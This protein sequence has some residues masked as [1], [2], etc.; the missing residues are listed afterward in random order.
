MAACGRAI[1]AGRLAGPELAYL[2]ETRGGLYYAKSDYSHALADYSEAIRLD[3]NRKNAFGG[4]GETY[5]QLGRRD[6]AIA[7]Y[8]KVLSFSLYSFGGDL[9]LKNTAEAGLKALGVDPQAADNDAAS[10]RKVAGDTTLPACDRAIAAGKFTGTISHSSTTIAP[11]R[12]P[13]GPT[14]ITPSPTMARRSSSSPATRRRSATAAG[15]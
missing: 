4:R 11:M 6:E 8:Y 3:P 9:A 7:D 10:C 2:Y 5:R 13:K 14:S 15:P 12:I 1:A